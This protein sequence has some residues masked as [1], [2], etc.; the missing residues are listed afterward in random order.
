MEEQRGWVFPS[1][2]PASLPRPFALRTLSRL[3]KPLLHTCSLLL[4][5]LSPSLPPPP[6]VPPSNSLSVP[7]HHCQQLGRFTANCATCGPLKGRKREGRL[8]T[9]PRGGGVYSG[10]MHARTDGHTEYGCHHKTPCL[11]SRERRFNPG[12]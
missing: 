8:G 3:A 5:F 10:A 11:I 2:T 4:S 6:L 9:V 1:Q 12:C 7:G